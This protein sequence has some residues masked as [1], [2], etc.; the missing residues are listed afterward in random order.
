MAYNFSKNEKNWVEYRNLPQLTEL[1]FHNW[2]KDRY[3]PYWEFL[4]DMENAVWDALKKAQKNK[5]EWLLVTHGS[6]T[7]RPG[8]TTARSITRRVMND[9]R[10]TPFIV[11]GQCIQQETVFLAKIRKE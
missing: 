3:Q 7:S 1:D 9:K 5:N 6:S 2:Y 4:D 8:K 10:A 11:R